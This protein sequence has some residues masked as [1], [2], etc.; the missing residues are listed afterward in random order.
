MRWMSDHRASKG[1]PVLLEVCV[2]SADDAVAAVKAGA[3]RIE[4]NSALA[5]GGL[6]PTPGLLVGV[7]PA[8][9]VPLIVMA[10]PRG[11][12]FCYSDSEFRVLR[13]DVEYTL[14]HGADGVA[15]G[16]LTIDGRVDTRR[17]GTVARL[18]TRARRN[19]VFHRAFDAIRKPQDALEQLI[20]LRFAR[21]MTSGGK[22]TAD[23][24]ADVIRRLIEQAAGRIEI[25]PAG[26]IRAGNVRRIIA[27]TG[28]DQ[29][30]SSARGRDGRMSA[31]AVRALARQCRRGESLGA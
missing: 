18:V 24:G 11:G 6:T 5:L 25:L 27:R 20:D 7:R 26:G 8:V 16:I 31:L 1:R 29:L 21:V 30:H 17:C 14:E 10:R 12:D 19:L 22:E 28:C 23:A 13:R 2:E 3:D 4:L 9:R 15:C